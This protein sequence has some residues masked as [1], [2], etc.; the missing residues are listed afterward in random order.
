MNIRIKLVLIGIMIPIAIYFWPSALGG[1]TEILIVQGQS[2]LP[3]ILPGSF[4]IAKQA[5]DYNI[6]DIVVFVQKSGTGAQKIVVHRIIEETENGFVIQ[7]DN[8]PVKDPGFYPQ[9]EILGTVLFATPY[10]G[11]MFALL[12]NPIVLIIVAGVIGA[13]QMEQK[14]R[15]AKKE[16]LRRIRLGLPK[17]EKPTE[18]EKKPKKPDYTLFY[19][20][21]AINIIVYVL[22]LFTISSG[23]KPS[24]DILTGFLFK[25]LLSSFAATVSFALYFVFIIGMYFLAKISVAKGQR[26][27]KITGRK[28]KSSLGSILGKDTNPVLAVASFL[29]LLF[30]VMELFHLMTLVQDV[31]KI[32][33]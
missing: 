16:K 9:E 10:V 24:G 28:P 3:T 25:G 2:M 31:S 22:V 20:A 32:I 7:G 18:G 4:V 1:T 6:G 13:I 11:D 26:R 17:Y 12:R 21:V 23:L 5:P 15:K 29:W 8:N 19:A 30:V 33:D 14:K 27:E